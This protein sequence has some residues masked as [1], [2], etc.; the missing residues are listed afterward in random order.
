MKKISGW[1]LIIMVLLSIIVCSNAN[2]ETYSISSYIAFARD[3][4]YND[5]F[6][7]FSSTKSI[8]RQVH[9]SDQ[10]VEQYIE[11]RNERN[12]SISL[13]KSHLCYRD[14]SVDDVW[15]I[16][17]L[18]DQAVSYTAENLS[19]VPLLDEFCVSSAIDI[20]QEKLDLVGESSY[21][22]PSYVLCI[23]SA[24]IN[25]I[26]MNNKGNFNLSS[27][28]Q[29]GFY[30][31]E[32]PLLIDEKPCLEYTVDEDL[33]APGVS[34]I[35]DQ[36]GKV[37]EMDIYSSYESLEAHD[38]KQ[39]IPSNDVVDYLPGHQAELVH[40]HAELRYLACSSDGNNND[41]KYT[42]L[43]PVW[44]FKNNDHVP[45]YIFDAYSGELL[46]MQNSP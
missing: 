29:A 22:N 15:L 38:E 28:S 14:S 5:I 19:E 17:L 40:A 42:R 34:A 21:G 2:G 20:F 8:Y 6:L 12:E 27:V 25:E 37:I 33:K 18:A 45:T 32:M 1:M 44:E 23:T 9:N 36:N 7:L 3:W 26:I 4:S 24:N 46:W 11:Y 35:I 30:Y 16:L 43:I 41:N 10:T 31:I 13:K 39:I